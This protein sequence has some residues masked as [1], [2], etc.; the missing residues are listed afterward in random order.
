MHAFLE[1]LE[2]AAAAI[3]EGSDFSVEDGLGGSNGLRKLL[4][5][6]VL[7]GDVVARTRAKLEFAVVKKSESGPQQAS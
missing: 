2:I 4:E 5:F 3:V 1:F 7:S 6:G